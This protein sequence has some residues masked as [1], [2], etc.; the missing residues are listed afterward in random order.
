MIQLDKK[1]YSIVAE[2]LRRLE[3]PITS[4]KRLG[5]YSHAK[6]I[7]QLGCETTPEQDACLRCT[8]YAVPMCV[9]VD[10]VRE[11]VDLN[12]EGYLPNGQPVALQEHRENYYLADI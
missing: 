12:Y 1:G 5:A 8:S 11:D 10:R 2:I 7:L 3:I 4:P 6:E 9:M